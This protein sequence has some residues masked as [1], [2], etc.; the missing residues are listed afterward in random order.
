MRLSTAGKSS[1]PTLWNFSGLRAWLDMATLYI[2]HASKPT[3]K[4]RLNSHLHGANAK[5]W[6]VFM[7][8]T[9]RTN[10]SCRQHEPGLHNTAR[11][12]SFRQQHEYAKPS[13]QFK[14]IVVQSSVPGPQFHSP[15]SHV[16]WCESS[17]WDGAFLPHTLQNNER[18]SNT[19]AILLSV[20]LSAHTKRGTIFR[21]GLAWCR[22]QL[23]CTWTEKATGCMVPFTPVCCVCV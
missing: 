9:T 7:L 6:W 5:R 4:S 14:Q 19:M 8:F 20:P 18:W 15:Y 23:G 1:F 3:V 16:N 13:T 22:S 11:T 2:K 17:M 12:T 10:E 21:P